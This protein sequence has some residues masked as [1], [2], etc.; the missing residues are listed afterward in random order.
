MS[1]LCADALEEALDDLRLP[2]RRSDAPANAACAASSS[3]ISTNSSAACACAMSPGPKT[4]ASMPRSDKQRRL[5]PERRGRPASAR[6]RAQQRLEAPRGRAVAKR[7]VV[8]H[9]PPRRSAC[10]AVAARTRRSA[11]ASSVADAVPGAGRSEN[12]SV[13]RVG[14]TL[15]AMPPSSAATLRQMPLEPGRPLVAVLDAH[16]VERD[17]RARQH[18]DRV[19]ACRRR[20]TSARPGRSSV[21]VAAPMPRW[22]DADAA[23]ASARRRSPARCP[24]AASLSRKARDAAARRAP[25]RPRTA[26]RPAARRAGAPAPPGSRRSRPWCRRCRGRAGGRRARTSR[27]GGDGVAAVGRHGVDVRVQ[28]QA[29]APRA[30]ARVDVGVLADRRLLDRVGAQ[31][32]QIRRQ[33]VHQRP[34]VPVGILRVER[35]QLGEPF[36]QAHAGAYSIRR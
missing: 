23:A 12:D 10:G 27:C 18:R 11:S 26:R 21:A 20:A 19:D 29:R 22:R 8:V 30:E 25:R 34:L 16:V 3:A 28:Q 31:R 35:H 9:R 32:A 33:P 5:G 14:T 6:A 1:A 17:R 2:S 15:N 36:G 7:R 24:R 13:A 4:T